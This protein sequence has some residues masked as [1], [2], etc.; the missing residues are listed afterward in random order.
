MLR[1]NGAAAPFLIILYGCLSGF[2]TFSFLFEPIAFFAPA[3][4]FPDQ[5]LGPKLTIAAG[6]GTGF[7]V[8]QA[9]PA[10]ADLHLLAGNIGF[11]IRMI[12]AGHRNIPLKPALP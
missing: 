5:T 11:T 9:I 2:V 10:V 4:Q 1:S 6:I 3:A 12:L 7:A 8:I